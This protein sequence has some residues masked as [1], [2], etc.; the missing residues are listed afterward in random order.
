LIN[1]RVVLDDLVGHM[2][3]VEFDWSTATRLKVNEQRPALRAEQVAR[4]RLTVQQ[5]LR[6][7][8]ADDRSSQAL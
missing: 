8:A 1:I 5:L 6:R 3:E 7:A 2:G 4:V